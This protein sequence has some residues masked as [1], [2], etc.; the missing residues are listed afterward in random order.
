MAAI[1]FQLRVSDSIGV[2]ARTPRS[3]RRPAI[4]GQPSRVSSAVGTLRVPSLSLKRLTAMPGARRP[5]SSRTGTKNSARPRL[6]AGLPSGR[7]RVSAISAVVAEVNHLVP[8]SRQPPAPS[9][10]ATVSV[11]RPTSEPPVRSV[12]HWPEVHMRSPDRV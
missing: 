10:R 12:I 4:A 7:P 8:Y 9:W 11:V 3:A 5:A 2:I 1:A 6:P